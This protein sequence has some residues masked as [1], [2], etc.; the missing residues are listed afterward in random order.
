MHAWRC[1]PWTGVVPAREVIAF[2]QLDAY[3]YFRTLWEYIEVGNEEL[4]KSIFKVPL[5]R[6]R[7]S[8]A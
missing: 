4:A 8:H 6:V 1:V 3:S 5:R 2:T 7:Q